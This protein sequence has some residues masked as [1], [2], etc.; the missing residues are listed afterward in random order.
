MKKQLNIYLGRNV[1]LDHDAF[2][3]SRCRAIRAGYD[4]ENCFLVSEQSASVDRLICYAAN[5]RVVIS[6]ARVALV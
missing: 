4:L 3:A 2:Q 1:R 5:V 6:A